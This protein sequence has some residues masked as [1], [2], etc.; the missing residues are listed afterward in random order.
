MSLVPRPP[1]AARPVG[2][3]APTPPPDDTLDTPAPIVGDI[4]SG[5]VRG[6]VPAV[7]FTGPEVAR[8][9]PCLALDP[10]ALA[11]PRQRPSRR[12][13]SQLSQAATP[14]SKKRGEEGTSVVE[15]QY[16]G[17]DDLPIQQGVQLSATNIINE[18]LASVVNK[19]GLSNLRKDAAGIVTSKDFRDIFIDA[20][21]WCFLH[22]I[23][24]L[25][26]HELI[27]HLVDGSLASYRPQPTRESLF[28]TLRLGG[29]EPVRIP[30][31]LSTKPCRRAWMHTMSP[32]API[33][34][35]NSPSPTSTSKGKDLFSLTSVA[36]ELET[37]LLSTL[38]Y[39]NTPWGKT[40]QDEKIRYQ[41]NEI[42]MLKLFRH[43]SCCYVRLLCNLTKRQ[44]TTVL[45]LFADILS[46][47]L[48][49]AISTAVPYAQ[50]H[51]DGSDYQQILIK[52]LTYWFGGVERSHPHPPKKAAWKRRVPRG[53]RVSVATTA[54]SRKLAKSDPNEGSEMMLTGTPEPS[55]LTV[56]QPG[57]L[58]PMT[59]MSQ[60]PVSAVS[61]QS[62]PR[63][64]HSTPNPQ[65]QRR[66]GKKPWGLSPDAALASEVSEPA[67]AGVL[68]LMRLGRKYSTK[69]ID[70]PI[71]EKE[72]F[73][74]VDA[75]SRSVVKVVGRLSIDAAQDMAKSLRA[76]KQ[77]LEAIQLSS[78]HNNNS[79]TDSP[80][81]T[82]ATAKE[83]IL[84]S[85]QSLQ[86]NQPWYETGSGSRGQCRYRKN[87]EKTAAGGFFSTVNS[88]PLVQ[89]Y[90]SD[91]GIP[92]LSSKPFD[93]KW[94]LHS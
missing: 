48:F 81:C 19:T 9:P 80:Q 36:S 58:S 84:Q 67:S 2:F 78:K 43:M 57:S 79:S 62:T 56:E 44:R 92:A 30:Q 82:T 10:S 27:G 41:Y 51:L 12:R 42:E 38:K 47:G 70:G 59:V 89:Q 66:R 39:P 46:E 24:F 29:Q 83:T 26:A 50:A 32:S 31:H 33:T 7:S 15:I 45:P 91:T 64:L 73:I 4:G 65:Q 71:E 90:L 93:M 14:T 40:L 13:S 76:C 63:I 53:R 25:P 37:T 52:R 6:S 88:S 35:Q 61:V 87:G 1:P 54:T 21:W 55:I 74:P 11:I 20:F 8:G 34:G 18:S 77:E 28:P 23:D 94:A 5:S 49:T 85:W 17:G 68:P 75:A 3:S 72:H 16:Q 69:S 60:I 86:A 22:D